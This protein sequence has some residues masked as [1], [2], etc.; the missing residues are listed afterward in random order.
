MTIASLLVRLIGGKA[1]DTWGRKAVLKVSSGFVLLAMII[2]ATA[3]T[4]LQLILGMSLYGFAQ[5][6]SSPTLLAWA[7]DLS[8]PNARGRGLPPLRS[9]IF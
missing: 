6:V 3:E 5:G 9:F 4:R 8:D 2:I 7:T 1:S